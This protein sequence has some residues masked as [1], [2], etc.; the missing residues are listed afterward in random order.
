MR[1][2]L[3]IDAAAKALYVTA[4][5]H[6]RCQLGLWRPRTR[7]D[8]EIEW[9]QMP[10]EDRD[11]YRDQARAV[12]EAIDLPAL[13]EAREALPYWLQR[14]RGLEEENRSLRYELEK[15]RERFV[16]MKDTW[17]I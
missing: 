6:P 16:E 4:Y 7:E 2:L 11:V 10:E 12:L 9:A 15:L 17:F 8:A 5:I 1:T 3:D 13:A 14:A